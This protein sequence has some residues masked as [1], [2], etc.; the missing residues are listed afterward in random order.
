M[1]E[2]AP[3]SLVLTWLPFW[4]CT[5]RNFLFD[6]IAMDHGQHD[7]GDQRVLVTLSKG[8]LQFEVRSNRKHEIYRSR[9]QG[10]I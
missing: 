8:A 2:A 5:F 3:D 10:I 9:C 1:S 7:I 6:L 4:K